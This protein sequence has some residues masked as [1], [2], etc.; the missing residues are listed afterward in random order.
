VKPLKHSSDLPPPGNKGRTYICSCMIFLRP[1]SG[2]KQVMKKWIEQLQGRSVFVASSGIPFRRV[3][4]QESN[5][6][7]GNQGAACYHPL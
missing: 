1:T 2:A 4:L 5:M 7:P 3:V 6:G